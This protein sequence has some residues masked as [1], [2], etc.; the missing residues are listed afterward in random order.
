LIPIYQRAASA[1][2]LGPQGAAVLAAINEVETAFGTNLNVSSAGAEGWMQFMPATW[3]EYGLDANDDGVKDPYNPEDAIFSA[4]G[5]LSASGMPA[6][7]YSAVFAYNHAD[8]YVA[9]VL[10]KAACY[11]SIGSA[12]GEGFSLTPQLVELDCKTTPQSPM[13]VPPDYMRAFEAAA[14]RYELG[15]SG[16]WAIAAVARLESDFGRGMTK[17]QLRDAGP[18]GLDDS[19]W[20]QFAVDGDEDGRLRRVDAD[21]S[22]ATLARLIWSRGGLRAGLFTHNQAKWYIDLVLSEAER[23]EGSC[24]TSSVDWRLMLPRGGLPINWSNLELSNELE[25]L[26]ISSG[27]LDPRVIA[28]LGA[29]TQRHR[30]TVSSLRSDHSQFTTSGNVSNHFFGRAIDI[31]AIDGV[32]CTDTA[33]TAPCAQIGYELATLSPP[34]L[35]PTELIY[36]FDLDGPGPAFALADHCDH[37]HAGF[38][39]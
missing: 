30:V 23:F 18:L 22:A 14:S 38:N 16:V 12:G 11:S 25:L 13:R 21:D 5:Y 26:D 9:D 35:R 6:D 10:S 2:A 15:R 8:W 32:S 17:K 39:D 19:E 36:C 1:Y 28:M 34:A 31:A 24:T 29:I 4:A 37:I 33:P 27:A 7:T 3:E 20:R